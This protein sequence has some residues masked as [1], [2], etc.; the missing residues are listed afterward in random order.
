MRAG[1]VCKQL[2]PSENAK[3]RH[4]FI[5]LLLRSKESFGISLGEGKITPMLF[6]TKR[7]F[8]ANKDRLKAFSK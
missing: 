7:L 5:G 3:W 2:S 6:G 1:V 4:F 8:P